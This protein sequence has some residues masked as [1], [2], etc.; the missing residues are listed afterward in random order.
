MKMSMKTKVIYAISVCCIVFFLWLGNE[1]D[2]PL[3]FVG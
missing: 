3:V 2:N 1:G